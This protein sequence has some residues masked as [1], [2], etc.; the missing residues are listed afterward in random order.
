[1][2]NLTMK[3][4]YL[5]FSLYLFIL[6]YPSTLFAQDSQYDAV[7]LSVIKEYTLNSDG[8]MDFRYAKEQKLQSYRSFHNLYG[9]TFIVYN[10]LYQN[11]KINESYTL[12]ANGKKVTT[13][14]NA[15]NEV[16]PG[17]AA[18]APAFNALREMVV[19]HTGLE[20][21]ATIYL[22]YTIHSNKGSFP[23]LGGNELL[24]EAEPLKNLIIRIRIPAE[25]DLFYKVFNADFPPAI[26]KE[27]SFKVYTWQLKDLSA[28]SPEDHQQG[29]RALY[30]R[31]IFSTNNDYS[32]VLSFLTDQPAFK[33]K[34]TEEMR[35]E[36][37]QWSNETKDPLEIALKIQEKVVNDFRL[38]DVPLRYT[39]YSC[40]TPDQ[41]WNSNYGNSLEK[42]LLLTTLLNSANIDAMP[43]FITNKDQYDDKISTFSCILDFGVKIKLKEVGTVWLSATSLNPVSLEYA[44]P[45][46]ILISAEQPSKYSFET[47]NNRGGNAHLLATF[48]V[49]SDPILTGE[50]SISLRGT[51]Y[52]WLDVLRDKNKIKNGIHG[53]IAGKGLTGIKESNITRDALFQTF[54]VQTDK[55]F[56]KDTGFFYFTLPDIG[57]GID[58]WNIKTLSIKRTTPYEIPS[59]IEETHQLAFTLPVGITLFTPVQKIEISNKA[60][61][62]LFEIK[63]NEGKMVLKR[64][65][66]IVKSDFSPETYQDFKSLMDQWNNPRH[67]E[68]IFRSGKK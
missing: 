57:S 20:R 36:V 15:F 35:S 30:P 3:T 60:G 54:S 8:S 53:S 21:N 7:Y 5:Q 17:F 26:T 25:V 6:S 32:K 33:S 34:P 55:P 68:L 59:E 63:Y 45:D 18:N 37:V 52:P 1:M 19:T 62:F 47:S 16:L 23:A 11:L 44:H 42:T 61:S 10:P 39:G 51:T 29:G 38:I 48:I 22:D 4:L 12:M 56:R 14:A 46:Q 64:Q 31:L 66:K 58:S 2:K 13:P 49:S 27:G 50:I 24:A 28:Y 41:V 43:S 40:R 65:I 9:E 67:R